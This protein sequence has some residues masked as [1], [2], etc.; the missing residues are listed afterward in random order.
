M[1][2]YVFIGTY[3]NTKS[4][5]IYGMDLSG[6]LIHEPVLLANRV[7]P[8]YLA[9]NKA[10]TAL[11][12]VDEPEKGSGS[13][14]SYRLVRDEEGHILALEPTGNAEAPSLGICHV[15]L[16]PDEKFLLVASYFDATVQVWA[17]KEDG[18]LGE[19]TDCLIREGQGPN[20]LRQEKAHAHSV[21]FA[22]DG[23]FLYVC[24]LGTDSL[25]A[26]RLTEEGKLEYLPERS[27]Q[28][29]GGYGPRHMTFSPDGK[30]AYVAAE[31][32]D[33]LLV[34]A[35]DGKTLTLKQDLLS[36]E[37]QVPSNT[38]AA[39]RVTRDGRHVYISNRGEDTVT[40]YDVQPDGELIECQRVEAQGRTPREFTLSVDEKLAFT[41][42]QD[43]DTIGVFHRDP[44]TGL[45]EAAGAV[46]TV[47]Q[48]VC[49]VAI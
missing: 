43:S 15:V 49:I 27:V 19:M 31:V 37:W 41:G 7:S 1:Q 13:L 34:Y 8:T 32:V 12:A 26:Y 11:Y 2:E 45:L 10:G 48:P 6:G 20:P 14:G 35:F 24:D 36:T 5:G 22:P 40:V 4:K 33:H 23:S 16:S 17:L 29:P 30:T 46:D 3:T 21:T 44:S 28:V 25:A 47:G 38:S 18:S 39:V 42:N 9:V